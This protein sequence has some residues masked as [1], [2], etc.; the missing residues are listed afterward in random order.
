MTLTEYTLIRILSGYQS[1]NMSM[2]CKLPNLVV[3]T[4]VFRT[5]TICERKSMNC[6]DVNINPKE[7]LVYGSQV[8]LHPNHDVAARPEQFDKP[9]K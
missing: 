2:G 5:N 8:I 3:T 4:P 7:G 6:N 1:D 9:L